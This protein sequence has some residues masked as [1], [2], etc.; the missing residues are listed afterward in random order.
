MKRIFVQIVSYRDPECHPTINDLFAKAAYPERIAVGLCWQF[1]AEA[2]REYFDVP[3]T[4]PRQVQV[5]EFPAS[6][7][8]G[9]GWARMQAQQFYAGEDY[10]LQ[11]QS[12]M[13]FEQGWD[14]VLIAALEGLPSQKAILT[15]WLPGYI[16]PTS[17]TKLNGQVPV[18]VL[19]RLG[20][21]GDAQMLHLIK[22]MVPEDMLT[23]PFL[24]GLW[25]GNFMFARGEVMREVPFDPHIYFWGEELNFSARLWTHGYDIYHM[26]RV[27]MYHYWDRVG[28]KD[29]NIY[30]DHRIDPNQRSLARN[31]HLFGL[32]PTKMDEALLDIERYPLG[33]ERSIDDYWKFIGVNWVDKTIMPFARQGVF[34]RDRA[35]DSGQ[36]TLLI[37][38]AAYR[39]PEARHTVRDAFAKATYP[40]RIRV[41]IC[42]QLGE[43]DTDCAFETGW[44][45]Q[46]RIHHVHYRES[47][48]ANWAR[49]QALALHQDEEYI[50]QI[51]S[52]MRFEE[53]WDEKLLDMHGRAPSSKAAISAYL[54]NYEPPA[55]YDQPEGRLLRMCVRRLGD[56]RD[57][58]LVHL[59]GRFV[60]MRSP[61]TQ[62]VRTPFVIANFLFGKAEI[63][64]Q[65]PL[66]PHIYFYGD[67]ISLSVRFW[68]HGVDVYQPDCVVAYHHWVRRKELPKHP[69]RKP[70]ERSERSRQRVRQLLGLENAT[71]ADAAVELERYGLGSERSL[72]D[73]WK[74]AGVNLQTKGI[75]SQAIT[76]NWP[77]R[78]PQAGKP[79]IFV[80]IAS[81]RDPELRATIDDLFT[82][83]KY[84]ERITAGVCCQFDPDDAESSHI[85][86]HM[87]GR[88][89]VRHVHWRDSGGV[90]WARAQTELMYGGEEYTLQIDSHSRF[91]KD[92]DELLIEELAACDSSKPVISC[93]PASY[94]P[95]HHLQMD[96]APTIRVAKPFTKEGNMRGHGIFL[97]ESPEKPLNGAFIAAG[98]VFSRSDIL[99]EVPY[100][101]FLYFNQEEIT[102]AIRLYTH[103]W[104]VF[105]ARRQF[106]YHYYN[107]SYQSQR[108]LHWNDI[109]T[110]DDRKIRFLAARGLARF[111]HLSGHR[112]ADDQRSLIDMDK[113]GLGDARSMAEFEEYC[114]VDFAAKKVSEKALKGHFVRGAVVRQDSNN[115]AS[116]M[117]LEVGDKLPYFELPAVDGKT[118]AIEKYVGKPTALFF[119][120]FDA[121]VQEKGFVRQIDDA[122][123]A[124]GKLDCW[125]IFI[126]DAPMQQVEDFKA[127]T[128]FPF[129]LWSD[130]GGKLGRSLGM[131]EAGGL[132]LNG[133]LQICGLYDVRKP[134]TPSQVVGELKR[135]YRQYQEN[136][137][138][139]FIISEIAPVLMVPNV[140]PPVWC[141]ELIAAFAKGETYQGTVGAGANEAYKPH[142]KKRRDWLVSEAWR[143]RL[144]EK[145]QRSL[146]P[147][148][149][150]VYGF[151]P[152]Y[153]ERY[154]VGQ[155]ASEEEGFFFSHRD[156][157]DPAM[158]YRR[159]ALTIN[160]N[161]DY[162]GGT[163]RFPEYGEHSYRPAK[164]GAIV[165]PC[166]LMHEVRSVTK[167]DRFMLVGFLHGEEQERYRRHYQE[168]HG[169]PI[170]ADAYSMKSPLTLSIPLS[171]DFYR[172][173]LRSLK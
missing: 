170:G 25:V 39:D 72:G 19:N 120:P 20:L 141:D 65:V 28:V 1:D 100:D 97:A 124:A 45:E 119:L 156:N 149:E 50:L 94:T 109:K 93:N 56:E 83:A 165:F 128:R 102:Y 48:G 78:L 23:A 77:M 161:D 172:R 44:P 173:W 103:G 47:K 16:P 82:N 86:S 139:R 12:H 9:A 10:I 166:D 135:M 127:A 155:Y 154:K 157:F 145:L 63:F 7:A 87:G 42:L 85:F 107:E 35:K 152:G 21:E 167:G 130:E 131:I 11:I 81:Y 58:Q 122:M 104:D 75:S 18:A 90:C 129:T 32:K 36:P 41:A 26:H 111:N 147:E 67:E 168:E 112:V 146:F 46:V 91:I 98:F 3:L 17:K 160:L 136:Y 101:P 73:F 123:F 8:Q 162:E 68:T 61:L 54:P 125:M 108:P 74:L 66:D 57:P 171:R 115:M 49:A 27:V 106:I 148:I 144:D 4:R 70:D 151:M 153:R 29:E 62:L 24:T 159:L 69:Y 53:G 99:C 34:A 132:L 37:A 142:S 40:D 117:S 55:Q 22:R 118:H 95:P 110:I 33:N 31:L 116:R 89:R 38:M 134:Q 121:L 15:A 133:N 76:G 113:F 164:G 43:E 143:D 51:D 158:G 137:A 140:L 126:V 71:D 60:D 84:P 5:V 114:G 80:R 6:E 14:E 64:K 59:T 138:D 88:V 163:L 150:K 2:D 96:P 30:R 52:H 13:R 92:W 79:E 105:S 169:L